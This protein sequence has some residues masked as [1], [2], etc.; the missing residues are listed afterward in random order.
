[1]NA[2]ALVAAALLILANAFFVAV[3]FALVAS[4]QTRIEPLAAEGSRSARA[5]LAAM[6]DLNLQLA[7][8]Q[9]GITLASV[10]LGFVGEPAVAALV[11]A[12]IRVVFDPPEAVLHGVSVVLALGIVVF[13][14][15]V[16]GEMVPKNLA[17]AG[18]ERS[19]LVLALPNQVYVT[20]FR[21]VIRVLTGMANGISRL[22]G[23]EP[24]SEVATV[25]TAEE[26]AAML[27]HSH[28]EG[29]IEPFE[30]DLLT[31]VLDFEDRRVDAV[32]VPR[33]SVVTLPAGATVADAE[34]LAVTS[35][36]S[37][38]PV[39]A[40]DDGEL[41][42]FVHAKDLL[43]LSPTAW[44]RPVPERVVRRML[45]VPP[46]RTLGDLLVAMRTARV[47]VAVVVD[48]AGAALGLVTLEDLL[49][50]LVGDIRDES[51]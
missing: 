8:A 1:M 34:R 46:E 16:L 49:E 40:S 45:R 2:W 36:H 11:E 38:L 37:R 10:L 17:I 23:V 30:R 39:V 51:D 22:F 35:G 31:G 19:L 42:G 41:T 13:L 7:G 48:P 9:L 24:R 50:E 27:A 43:M 28:A 6:Q 26:F 29:L 18:P 25:H 3:E 15:M 47:H 20:L 14:H 44:D 5:A 12:P 33:A 21:P 32:M 4:R